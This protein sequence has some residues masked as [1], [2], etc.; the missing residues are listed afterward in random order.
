MTRKAN[1]RDG[2]CGK[3]S[4]KQ[5]WRHSKEDCHGA[6][7]LGITALWVALTDLFLAVS[8][9]AMG[10]SLLLADSPTSIEHVFWYFKQPVIMT[11]HYYMGWP[12]K[13]D[14]RG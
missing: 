2:L 7:S 13:A 9:P 4:W 14:L 5:A 6:Q 11:D 12:Y 10:I 1:D 8:L 3:S